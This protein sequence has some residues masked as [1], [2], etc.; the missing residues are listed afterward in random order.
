M[1]NDLE[2]DVCDLDPN[3][4]CDNCCKC[5]EQS[6]DLN[7]NGYRVIMAEFQADGEDMEFVPEQQSAIAALF[8]EKDE[9][10]LFDEVEPLDIPPE[11]LSE[12]EERLAASFQKDEEN[13]PRQPKLH[14]SRKRR[15]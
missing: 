8:D 12:W 10:E 4:I 14:A 2:N 15:S 7:E 9:E 1:N 3:K 5:L 13:E 11:L 6:D